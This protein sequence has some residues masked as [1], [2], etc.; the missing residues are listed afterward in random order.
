MGEIETSIRYSKEIEGLLET[1]FGAEGRGLHEKVS[2]VEHQLP[3]ELIRKLRYIATIRNKVV[4]E[5]GY[6]I[7]NFE[8]F[9]SSCEEALNFLRT[10]GAPHSAKPSSLTT[11]EEKMRQFLLSL[12]GPAAILFSIIGG[13]LAW[14]NTGIGAG[15]VAAMV[16]G[17]IGSLLF[18]EGAVE[19]YIAVFYIAM[20]LAI[21]GA[22][23]AT[24]S[25]L[26]SFG[27][28]GS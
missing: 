2:S 23:I 21:L 4:H 3:S 24:I 11:T 15:I 17:F 7:D 8:N 16:G 1:R 20:G 14:Y 19:F 26:W 18:S 13:G 12:A 25:A 27:K 28:I 5:A 22:V 9:V 6:Q 10:A